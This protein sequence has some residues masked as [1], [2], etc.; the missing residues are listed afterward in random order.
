MAAVDSK[1]ALER[2]GKEGGAEPSAV[3]IDFRLGDAYRVLD[4]LAR[5]PN[6]PLIV[7]VL[8]PH[9]LLMVQDVIDA[10]FQR[11][12][13]AARLFARVVELIAKRR[14]SSKRKRIT[15][16]VAAVKGNALFA[17]ACN[18]LPPAVPIVNAG[19]I[20]EKVMG[21]LNVHPTTIEVADLAAAIESGRL[22]RA[23]LP[24]SRPELLDVAMERLAGVC[25]T[26][27]KR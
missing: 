6:R 17:A 9:E 19:A 25:S 20:M 13:D 7:G 18:A 27:A 5:A 11:P 16:V 15:G 22:K 26:F 4:A 10:A 14:G 2:Y 12:V 1:A 24:F 3:V 23:L 8:E 21:E